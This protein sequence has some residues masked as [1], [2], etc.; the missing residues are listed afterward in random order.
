VVDD[1]YAL[2]GTM[3]DTAAAPTSASAVI[4][5]LAQT[6]FWVS[7]VGLLVVSIAVIVASLPFANTPTGNAAGIAAE[8][9]FSAIVPLFGTWVG[10]IIAHYFS[11]ENFKSASDSVQQM[12]ARI[13]PDD[14]LRATPVK[15]AMIPR[16]KMVAETVTG[17][18]DAGVSF[19]SLRSKLTPTV[20]RV[21]I[22]NNNG[23][24]RYVVHESLIYRYIADNSSAGAFNPQQHNLAN[25]V[26]HATIGPMLNQFGFVSLEGS[27]ADA[28]KAMEDIQGA[29]DV[30]VTQDGQRTQEVLGWLTN[31]DIQKNIDIS[32][33]QST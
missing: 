2:R 22:L 8:K 19:A 32:K 25:L 21:P 1:K 15:S 3:P 23:T 28:K 14:Q 11:R 17:N 33:A 24:A 13:S 7:T 18:D 27:L 5:K 6:V 26:Q 29:Q 31:V 20:T 12:A 10:A 9:V 4:D 30:F 16:D